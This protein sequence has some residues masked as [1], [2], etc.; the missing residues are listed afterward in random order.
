SGRV[1]RSLSCRLPSTQANDR[2]PLRG[3]A[4]SSRVGFFSRLPTLPVRTPAAADSDAAVF[5]NSPTPGPTAAAGPASSRRRGAGTGGSGPG[6][7]RSPGR[8]EDRPVE[9]G[10][11]HL[12][13]HPALEQLFLDA[14]AGRR[15]QLGR[16][17]LLDHYQGE[18]LRRPDWADQFTRLGR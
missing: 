12:R 9:G 13:S 3:T 11:A 1:P 17:A 4:F 18:P 10:L 8:T 6:A 2:R 7:S 16:P 15:V 14:L 5:L